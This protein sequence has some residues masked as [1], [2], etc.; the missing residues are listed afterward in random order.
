M[1]TYT[2]E[3]KYTVKV[4]V[5]APDSETAIMEGMEMATQTVTDGWAKTEPRI[6]S[7]R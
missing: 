4:D 3:V 7:E 5:E 2:I 1:K 6:I